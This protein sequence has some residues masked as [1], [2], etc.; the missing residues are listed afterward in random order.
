MSAWPKM[1][2]KFVF[3][4]RASASYA[5][6]FM[7]SS[8]SDGWDLGTNHGEVTRSGIF[9][10]TIISIREEVMLYCSSCFVVDHARE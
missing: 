3:I 9:F 1:F 2:E 7:K 5:V 6:H 10:H 4:S 8:S